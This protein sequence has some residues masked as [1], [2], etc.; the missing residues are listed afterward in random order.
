VVLFVRYRSKIEVVADVLS[1]ALEGAKK[2]HIMYRGNLSFRL[3]NA[4]L[5]VATKAGLISFD[6]VSGCYLATDKGKLFLDRF[7][8]YKRLTRGLEKQIGLVK[9]EIASLEQMCLAGNLP[10]NDL[11]NENTCGK[12]KLVHGKK[13]I[14]SMRR[15]E[16]VDEA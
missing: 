8:R 9:S 13:S 5:G 6:G 14:D 16:V 15:S 10:N 7:K 11:N 3:V 1:A 2:T 12:S 4:Y